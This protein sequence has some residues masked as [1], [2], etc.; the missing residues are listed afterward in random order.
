MPRFP[1]R[2]ADI[3]ALAITIA[4]GAWNHPGDFPNINASEIIAAIREY[5]SA[6]DSQIQA[7]AQV[8]LATETKN[9]SLKSLK[10][11]MRNYL[12]KS[13]VDVANSP[14]KLALIGWGPKAAYQ[15]I[16]SPG[17]PKNLLLIKQ[18]LTTI[19]LK[20]NRPTTDSGGTVRNYI[21]ER[22]EQPAVGGEFGAWIIVGSALNNEINLT[23]QPHGSQLEYRV[24]A[25]NAAGISLS[26]N[27]IATVL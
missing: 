17:Q 16:A 21:I 4:L 22:R 9:I 27:S 11:M 13:E 24:K 25:V 5:S 23:N 8:Q 18:G 14:E 6:T 1:T 10:D 7:K 3:R 2:Q 19:K 12:K 20:W 15:P 26:S